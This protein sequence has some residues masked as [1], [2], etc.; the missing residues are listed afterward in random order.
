MARSLYNV[1]LTGYKKLPRTATKRTN[2]PKYEVQLRDKDG[3]SHT[4]RTYGYAWESEEVRTIN[5][6]VDR[7]LNVITDS[8]GSYIALT[9]VEAN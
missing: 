4:G 2:A 9:P 6:L 1:T 7:Q 5:Q 8:R 3:N